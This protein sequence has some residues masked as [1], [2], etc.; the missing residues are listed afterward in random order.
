MA[1]EASNIRNPKHAG[2]N[3]KI[4]NNAEGLSEDLIVGK[5]LRMP[6]NSSKEDA[7]MRDNTLQEPQ[8][9]SLSMV[10]LQGNYFPCELLFALKNPWSDVTT[11]R[12]KLTREAR[13][14][15]PLDAHPST[16]Q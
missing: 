9:A 16:L 1:G 12:P 7:K 13:P 11:L 15:P 14:P 3:A 2:G 6:Q 4:K 5:N 10:L 8:I